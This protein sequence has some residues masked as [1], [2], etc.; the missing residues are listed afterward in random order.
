MTVLLPVVAA[1]YGLPAGVVVDTLIRRAAAGEAPTDS[2][3]PLDR[4]LQG[5]RW[6]LVFVPLLA[7]VSCL[8]AALRWADDPVLVPFLFFLPLLAG[9]AVVDLYTRRLPNVLTGPALLGGLMLVIGSG[10]VEG[11]SARTVTALV[12]GLLLFV[13]LLLLN[14]LRPAGLGMGDVKVAG[15]IGL[16]IGLLGLGPAL[17]AI[18]LSAVLAWL[19]GLGL[20]AGGRITGRTPVPFGPW[21]A[22]GALVAVLAGPQMVQAYLDALS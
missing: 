9:L 21:L 16:F 2:G 7:G 4:H 1:V 20:I 15:L 6:R 5:G 19:A 12:S 3:P 14:L 13:A 8:A 11:N 10:V 22:V 18:T 17:L